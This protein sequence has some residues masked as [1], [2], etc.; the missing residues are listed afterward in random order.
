MDKSQALMQLHR[1][2]IVLTITN[3]RQQLPEA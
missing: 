3:H 2:D 1:A